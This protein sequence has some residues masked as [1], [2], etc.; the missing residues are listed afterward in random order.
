MRRT[1]SFTRFHGTLG[2]CLSA[3]LMLFGCDSAETPAR[4]TCPAGTKPGLR[5]ELLLGRNIGAAP[6]VGDAEFRN[7][8]DTEVTTRFPDG[9]TVVDAAGQ[10]RDTA[11][12]EIV[13]EQAK[14]LLVIYPYGGDGSRRLQ[15]VGEA[16][17][18]RFRQQAV[19]HLVAPTCHNL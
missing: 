7:F 13:R 9:F 4:L 10:W 11:R 12:A 8:L 15:A 3:V 6:G 1:K 16:Y 17:A 2:L 14:L 18:L 19:L 5:A